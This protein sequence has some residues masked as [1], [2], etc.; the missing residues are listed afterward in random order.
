MPSSTDAT[1]YTN[2]GYAELLKRLLPPDGPDPA[3]LGPFVAM[4]MQAADRTLQFNQEWLR[5][6]TDRITCDR[7]LLANLANPGDPAAIAA[8]WSEFVSGAIDDYS[9]LYRRLWGQV[10][11]EMTAAVFDTQKQAQELFVTSLRVAGSGEKR[12]AT[13][14]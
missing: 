13:P 6:T 5:F 8:A 2:A 1:A 14:V 9:A 11:E 12:H 7:A 10:A 3:L 4:Q